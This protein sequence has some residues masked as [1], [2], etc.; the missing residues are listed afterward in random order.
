MRLTEFYNRKLTLTNV[1]IMI[2]KK[3]IDVNDR[4]FNLEKSIKNFLDV[5]NRIHRIIDN[6]KP[7]TETEYEDIKRVVSILNKVKNFILD[8]YLNRETISKPTE[9]YKPQRLDKALSRY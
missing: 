7:K 9:R 5:D 4:L 6:Y 1:L 2:K 3:K 8:F